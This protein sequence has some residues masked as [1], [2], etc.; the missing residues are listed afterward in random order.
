MEHKQAVAVAKRYVADI[1]EEEA[2]SNLGVEEIE[3]D[4]QSKLWAI[5]VAF[6]RPWNT[7]RTRAQEILESIGSQ[8][9]SLKR[10]SKVITVTEDGRVVSM[11]RPEHED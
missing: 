4:D 11:K 3:F 7:P 6:S 2:I 9:P 1:Y 5:R 8:A 10:T